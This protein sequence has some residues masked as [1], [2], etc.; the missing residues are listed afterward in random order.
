VSAGP[1]IVAPTARGA[2]L[3]D[4]SLCDQPDERIFAR[5]H[6]RAAGS[7][8]ETAGGRGT[9]AFIRD[10]RHGCCA[11]SV[12]EARLDSSTTPSLDRCGGTQ[13]HQWRLLR[14]LREWD[15]PVPRPI[16]ARYTGGPRVRADLITEGCR[17]G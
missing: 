14:H 15:L 10:A 16:A 12:A 1:E 3:Y 2:M 17:R 9:V 13:L 6:W 11:T 4:A 5:G 8:Q 7:L